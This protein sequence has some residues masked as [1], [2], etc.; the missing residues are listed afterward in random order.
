MMVR[1]TIISLGL[2]LVLQQVDA[3]SVAPGARDTGTALSGFSA[4]RYEEPDA[5]M[6]E[7]NGVVPTKQSKPIETRPSA[8]S[9]IRIEKPSDDQHDANYR[10][11]TAGGRNSSGTPRARIPALPQES[12]PEAT[13]DDMPFPTIA[14]VQRAK[15]KPQ[16]KPYYE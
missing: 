12:S 6:M 15:A 4:F 8:M 2:F 11:I 10:P 16:A 5:I 1:S 9:R 14:A 3:F 13:D 7:Q